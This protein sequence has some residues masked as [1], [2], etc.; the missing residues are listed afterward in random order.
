MRTSSDTPIF[1]SLITEFGERRRRAEAE[2]ARLRAL[3]ADV[4]SLHAPSS[5]GECPTCGMPSPCPSLLLVQGQIDLDEAC[6]AVRGRDVDVSSPHRRPNVPKLAEMLGS[7][8]GGVDRFFD[9]LLK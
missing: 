4:E 9:A 3:L 7:A 6:A 2:V 5:G 8:T 1:S